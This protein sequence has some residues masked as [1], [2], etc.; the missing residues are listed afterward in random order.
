LRSTLWK[1]IND[2]DPYNE[3]VAKFMELKYSFPVQPNRFAVAVK[4]ELERKVIYLNYLDQAAK[5]LEAIRSHRDKELSPRWQAN[6]DLIYAQLLAY[7]AR[8]YEYGASLERFILNPKQVPF[9]KPKFLRLSSWVIRASSST[10]GGNLTASYV[11]R[12]S[13]MFE[14]LIQDHP[15]TP[16][17][18]RAQWELERGFGFE[19]REHYS[20]YGPRP[21]SKPGTPRPKIP[22]PKL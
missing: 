18:A 8:S 7:T 19:L 2:L 10:V 5:A 6:Y 13:E 22:I 12:S 11:Q 4:T 16:W 17:A 14:Q 3:D 1:I 21:P 20:Y 15:G 9:E